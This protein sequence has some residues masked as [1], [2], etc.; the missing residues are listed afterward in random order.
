MAESGLGGPPLLGVRKRNTAPNTFRPWQYALI[1]FVLVMGAIY[2]A[3]NLFQP[4]PAL[5]IRPRGE[6][7]TLNERQQALNKLEAALADS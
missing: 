2:S 7:M 4:D 3:P 5:Q 1:L 6:D